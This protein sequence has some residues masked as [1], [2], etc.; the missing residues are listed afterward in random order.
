MCVKAVDTCPFV[1][2][3]VPDQ[4]KTQEVFNKAVSVYPFMLKY[5]LDRYKTQKVYDKAVDDFIPAL[6]IVRNWLFTS[7]MNEKFHN[8]LF[9]DDDSSNVTFSSDEMGIFV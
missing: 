4:Y 3:S 1:F 9:F 5:Y 7:K 6:K 2:E 8:G